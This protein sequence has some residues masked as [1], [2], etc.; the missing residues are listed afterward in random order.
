MIKKL[1]VTVA[2]KSYDVT[3]EISD[4]DASALAPV[5]LA[6]VAHVL[7]STP[8]AP[9]PAASIQVTSSPA[10]AAAPAKA[11]D[12]TSPLAG[13]VASIDV[14]PGQQVAQGQQV[15]TL[16]AM[17]MNTYIYA[18]KAGRIAAVYVNAGDA[19]DEGARLMSIA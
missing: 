10:A 11:G 6:P 13:K 1:R 16:E 9:P 3:V 17:K 7:A 2:G 15:M 8:V 12:V 19:V 5:A 14:Q 18:P 4:E